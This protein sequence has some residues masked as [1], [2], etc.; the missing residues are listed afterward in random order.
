MKTVISLLFGSVLFFFLN[1]CSHQ[2]DAVKKN[3][4]SHLV[5]V[6]TIDYYQDGVKSK[7]DTLSIEEFDEKKQLIR[8]QEYKDG[9]MSID[10]KYDYHGNE[11]TGLFD[12]KSSENSNINRIKRL[13]IR[14]YPRSRSL[15]IVQLSASGDTLF[16]SNLKFDQHHNLLQMKS[17]LRS[18]NDTIEN[19]FTYD[20]KG[21]LTYDSQ[22]KQLFENIYQD[23]IRTKQ[24]IRNEEQ[25]IIGYHNFTHS[26]DTLIKETY[27]PMSF[28]TSKTYTLQSMKLTRTYSTDPIIV[29]EVYYTD[30]GAIDYVITRT[31]K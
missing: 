10:K 17:I 20:P 11:I 25:S 16:S 9:T 1:S 23:E 6:T 13:H 31:L 12:Y 5:L 27:G 8:S 18:A 19:N 29:K 15:S 24:I 2:H 28:L 3:E 4:S 14:K 30:L 22:K 21:N 7:S 26:G